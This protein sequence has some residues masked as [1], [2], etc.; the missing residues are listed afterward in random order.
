[1]RYTHKEEEKEILMGIFF[2]IFLI[3]CMFLAE[4]M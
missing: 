1:M 3:I 4:N 2:L